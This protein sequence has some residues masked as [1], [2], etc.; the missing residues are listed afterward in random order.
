MFQFALLLLIFQPEIR[1]A[2]EQIA[3]VASGPKRMGFG[4]SLFPG[5]GKTPE[6]GR[7][8]M[9]DAA[10]QMSRQKTGALIVFEMKPNW[11]IS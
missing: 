4:L 8:S 2:L 1:R 10:V 9:P 3:A 7:Q 6:N 5:R 11:E